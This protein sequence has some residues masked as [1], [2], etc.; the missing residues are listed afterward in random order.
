MTERPD[1]EREIA[2]G[3]ATQPGTFA[4]H[5]T[6]YLARASGASQ[7]TRGTW[8]LMTGYERFEQAVS[9]ALTA[10]VSVVIVVTLLRISYRIC[11]LLLFEIFDPRQPE[12]FQAIFGMIMTVLIALELNHSILSVLERRHGIVQVRTVVLI[13]ILA[14]VRKFIL[15]DFTQETPLMMFGLA[16]SAFALGAVYWLVR[17]SDP[18]AANEGGLD[19]EP[20]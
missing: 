15:I 2:T 4:G 19:G 17:D 9:L 20:K 7:E 14:L 13:A 11:I 1:G 10:L 5:L 3:A 12:I 6:R 16:A 18:Y 8:A